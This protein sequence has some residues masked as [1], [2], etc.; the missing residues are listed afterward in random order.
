M[1]FVTMLIMLLYLLELIIH[2][3]IRHLLMPHAEAPSDATRDDIE[4]LFRMK[5]GGA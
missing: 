3:L 1:S 2:L 4:D 5:V